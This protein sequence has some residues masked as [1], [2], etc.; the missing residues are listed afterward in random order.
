MTIYWSRILEAWHIL[1]G[2]PPGRE[3]VT[4]GNA[5]CIFVLCVTFSLEN[6]LRSTP[7]ANCCG[8]MPREPTAWKIRQNDYSATHQ[9]KTIVANVEGCTSV[10]NVHNNS[11]QKPQR[12]MLHSA[13]SIRSIKHPRYKR[14]HRIHPAH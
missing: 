9:A 3:Q 1:D 4:L 14:K 2:R 7:K 6:G 8:L 11:S 13:R 5:I 12:M 10:C